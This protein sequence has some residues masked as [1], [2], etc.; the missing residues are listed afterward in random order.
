MSKRAPHG[1]LWR[2][3]AG[4]LAR[5]HT[6][7]PTVELASRDYGSRVTFNADGFQ[8]GRTTFDEL[9]IANGGP[10][11]ESIHIEHMGDGDYFVALGREKRMVRFERDGT[12]KVGE[13]YE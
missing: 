12:I 5:G 7:E 11:R 1:T 4:G 10:K 3:R 6:V 13:K 9:V 2:I 8:A